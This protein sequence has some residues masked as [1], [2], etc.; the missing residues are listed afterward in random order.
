MRNSVHLRFRLTVLLLA[1]FLAT[2]AQWDLM[3]TF[4][5]T[6]MFVNYSR[7]MTLWQ[8]ARQTF[9]GEMCSVCRIVSGAKDSERKNTPIGEKLDVKLKF[10]LMPLATFAVPAATDIA[11]SPSDLTAHDTRRAAPPTPP[12]RA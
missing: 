4:A 9:S 11:W 10:V 5:W 8:A 2:G 12:P 3:Q 1:T 6:R 7:T